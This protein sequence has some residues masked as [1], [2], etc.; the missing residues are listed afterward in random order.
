MLPWYSGGDEVCDDS[1]D[2]GSDGGDDDDDGG[3]PQHPAVVTRS[4]NHGS[5]DRGAHS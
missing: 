5:V 4:I 2:D 3:V 1:D